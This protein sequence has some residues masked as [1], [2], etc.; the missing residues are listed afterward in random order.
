MIHCFLNRH[1]PIYKEYTVVGSCAQK[2]R[3]I[4]LLLQRSRGEAQAGVFRSSRGPPHR[5]R[6]TQWTMQVFDKNNRWSQ[7]KGSGQAWGGTFLTWQLIIYQNSASKVQDTNILR[8]GSRFGLSC[9]EHS[10]SVVFNE[11]S[12]AF[13]MLNRLPFCSRLNNATSSFGCS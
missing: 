7:G 11:A 13:S 10:L 3:C 6:R 1:G 9:T 12:T 5:N 2:Y 8:L 4:Q